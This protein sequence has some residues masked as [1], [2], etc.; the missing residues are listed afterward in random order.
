MTSTPTA[1]TTLFASE[2]HAID[3]VLRTMTV[4]AES[5]RDA[6]RWTTWA[7]R[8]VAKYEKKTHLVYHVCQQTL[9]FVCVQPL[10]AANTNS[11]CKFGN[12]DSCA[13]DRCA[14]RLLGLVKTAGYENL[15]EEIAQRDIAAALKR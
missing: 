13:T 4:S 1:T 2:P 10:L 3:R 15:A 12:R 8:P 7:C 11:S 6:T 5:H 9:N 14:A